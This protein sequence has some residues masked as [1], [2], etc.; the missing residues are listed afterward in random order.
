MSPFRLVYGK[1]CHLLVEQEHHALWALKQLNF[2]LPTAGA[3]R[4]LQIV[5]MEEMRNEAYHS[6]KIYKD[7]IKAFHGKSILRI[8]FLTNQKVLLYNSRLHLFQG[9]LRSRWDGPYMV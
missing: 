5:E 1:A 2:D 3:N 7:K 9:K 6:T 4:K 8:F